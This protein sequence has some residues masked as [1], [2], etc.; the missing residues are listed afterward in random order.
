MRATA[1]FFAIQRQRNR[2]AI[3]VALLFFVLVNL[4]VWAITFVL[5]VFI[6]VFVL[7]FADF[8]RKAIP[9]IN[10]V[11]PLSVLIVGSLVAFAT[12]LAFY[13]LRRDGGSVCRDLGGIPLQDYEDGRQARVLQNV[14]EELTIASQMPFRPDIYVLPSG[15]INALAAGVRIDR[16]A[17]GVTVGALERLSREELAA[18][19][20]HEF[21]HLRYGDCRDSSYLFAAARGLS[22]LYGVGRAVTR[23]LW[24]SIVK[25]ADFGVRR[26]I[27]PSDWSAAYWVWHGARAE[28][29]PSRTRGEE[30]TASGAAALLLILPWLFAWSWRLIA[31][32]GAVAARLLVMAGRRTMEYRADAYALQ[33]VRN[34]AAIVGLFEKIVF[35]RLPPRAAPRSE[36]AHFL[37]DAGVLGQTAMARYFS[38][39]EWLKLAWE[40]AGGRGFGGF[41]MRLLLLTA[42]PLLWLLL[43]GAHLMRELFA[44]HPDTLKRIRAIDPT[45][46]RERFRELMRYAISAAREEAR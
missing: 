26:S 35:H 41:L 1:D 5:A 12:L 32:I 14:V 38:L 24:F 37:I 2:Q 9:L 46:P 43:R 44:T 30:S 11:W 25:P 19:V 8:D 34:P 23:W 4:T 16:L 20:A 31:G 15:S 39:F 21:G 6:M 13:R 36:Y 45:Y 3:F 18:L 27:R 10:Y 29:A 33:M 42:G 17:V 7:L 22:A 28:E 40:D